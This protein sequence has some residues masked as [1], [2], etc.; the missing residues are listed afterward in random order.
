[1]G[2][3]APGMGVSWKK[4]RWGSSKKSYEKQNEKVKNNQQGIKGRGS[5]SVC[6]WLWL[7]AWWSHG[8]GPFLVSLSEDWLLR[9]PIQNTFLPV[10][11]LLVVMALVVAVVL[12]PIIPVIWRRHWIPLNEESSFR[13]KSVPLNVMLEVSLALSAVSHKHSS[14]YELSQTFSKIHVCFLPSTEAQRNQLM[15]APRRAWGILPAG[16]QCLCTCPAATCFPE[17]QVDAVDVCNFQLCI[18]I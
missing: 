1:M 4:P 12:L 15:S 14:L 11:L 13:R 8:F 18:Y 16:V 10:F 6:C 17:D 7:F 9:R 2:L 3:W 5:L